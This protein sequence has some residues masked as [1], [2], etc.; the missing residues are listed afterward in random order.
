MSCVTKNKF[1]EPIEVQSV[2]AQWK[3]RGFGCSIYVDAPGQEWPDFIHPCNELVMVL[4]GQL[5]MLVEDEEFIAN[6]GDEVFIPKNTYHS[7]F[8][9]FNGT[10][11]WFYGYD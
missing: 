10:T 5:R 9:T 7:L 1:I 3:K 4:D 8:N 11:R 2:T 6:P